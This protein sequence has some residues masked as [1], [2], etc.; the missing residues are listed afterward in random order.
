[1]LTEAF[2]QRYVN[3]EFE[4]T[5]EFVEWIGEYRMLQGLKEDAIQL[6]GLSLLPEAYFC[7]SHL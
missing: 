5:L 4:E 6:R 2:V 1:M 3:D 7:D